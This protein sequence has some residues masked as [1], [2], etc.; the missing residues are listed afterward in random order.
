MAVRTRD[1]HCT[2][3]R[4]I[5]F[6]NATTKG[7]TLIKIYLDLTYPNRTK[8]YG[9]IAYTFSYKAILSLVF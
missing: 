6:L 2:N 4:D 8:D 5:V 9:L 3:I 7:E 1:R